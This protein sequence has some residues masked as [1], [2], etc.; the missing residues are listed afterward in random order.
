MR[1]RDRISNSLRLS[2]AS[3]GGGNVPEETF[4]RKCPTRKC[5]ATF[6]RLRFT[7]CER[8]LYE[9]LNLLT[10]LEEKERL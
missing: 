9:Q 10:R 3:R 2:S 7:E 1:V 4:R 5:V 6:Q 8:T